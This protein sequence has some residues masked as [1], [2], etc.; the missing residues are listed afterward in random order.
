[1]KI[2]VGKLVDINKLEDLVEPFNRN[3][4][5]LE[6]LAKAYKKLNRKFRALNI[7]VLL[8]ICAK[9]LPKLKGE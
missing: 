5:D 3:A 8:Y 2:K 4:D 9:E 1:M 7:I 6:K